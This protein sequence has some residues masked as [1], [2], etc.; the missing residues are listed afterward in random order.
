MLASLGIL[1]VL[2]SDRVLDEEEDAEIPILYSL[3]CMPSA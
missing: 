3:K 2:G 1:Y